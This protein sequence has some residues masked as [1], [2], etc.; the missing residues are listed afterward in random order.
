MEKVQPQ[1][2]YPTRSGQV[3]SLEKGLHP[4]KILYLNNIIG[5]WPQNWNS[6]KI[7]F[8]KEGNEK[9]QVLNTSQCFY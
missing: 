3:I 7:S 8:K 9:Y 1:P 2:S 6:L 4:I 5:G